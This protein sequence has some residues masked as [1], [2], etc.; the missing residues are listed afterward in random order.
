MF[1]KSIF[2][3]NNLKLWE[4]YPPLEQKCDESILYFQGKMLRTFGPLLLRQQPLGR[5]A[6]GLGRLLPA[7]HQ[8]GSKVQNYALGVYFAQ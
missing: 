2:Y 1:I 4:R 7:R 3:L 8:N 6:A 5:Q